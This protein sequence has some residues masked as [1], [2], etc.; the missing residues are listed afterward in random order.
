MWI[1][2]TEANHGNV[3]VDCT[4]LKRSAGVT[5]LARAPINNGR[6]YPH[7]EAVL[8]DA[9]LEGI[10]PV[11]WGAMGGDTGQMRYWEYNSTNLRD[12][13]PVD[14]SRRKPESKQLTMPGDA[15]TIANYRNPSWVLGWT[16]AMAP[17][18][19]G[20]PQAAMSAGTMTIGVQVAAVPDPTYQWLENG[21]PISGATDRTL[22]RAGARP[23][24]ASRYSVRVSNASGSVTSAAAIAKS[25]R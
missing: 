16:P 7:A 19:L 18:L 1:R 3:F 10:S 6:S 9:K 21:K 12:G 2:N 4:F 5:E 20:R 24:D 8:I 13:S 23:S 22:V 11:G 17:L 15:G 25:E 14:V